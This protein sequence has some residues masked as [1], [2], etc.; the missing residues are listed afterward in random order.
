MGCKSYN[1]SWGTNYVFFKTKFVLLRSH[2]CG[3]LPQNIM[4]C[5]ILKVTLQFLVHDELMMFGF[6]KN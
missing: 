3:K 2:S 4:V 5:R 6:Y 1:R